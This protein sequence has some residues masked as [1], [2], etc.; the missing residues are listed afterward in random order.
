[1]VNHLA[2]AALL[3]PGDEVALEEPTYGLLL[4][5][6]PYL[7]ARVQRVARRFE[8]N[9]QLSFAEMEEAITPATR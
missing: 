9:F 2:M 1:M 4:D 5:L 3:E 6:L 8:N 7:R